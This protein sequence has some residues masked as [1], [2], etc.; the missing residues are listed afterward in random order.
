ME[1]PEGMAM[2]H[3]RGPPAAG[4]PPGG[5]PQQR[6]KGSGEAV[7]DCIKQGYNVTSCVVLKLLEWM[8]VKR[9]EEARLSMFS[10]EAAVGLRNFSVDTTAVARYLEAVDRELRSMFPLVLRLTV[11]T[12]TPLAVHLRNPYMPLEIGLAW[13]PLFNAPYIPA[14]TL[15]GAL[16]AGARRGACGLPPADL[17]GYVGQEG[18]LVI[19]DA[20]PTSSAAVEPDVITPHYK[21]PDVREDRAEPTPLVFPVV[22]PGATFDFFVASRS[23]EARC[24]KEIYSLINEALAEGL[25]AKTR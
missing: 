8:R 22:K 18:A 25:G 1:P 14:T 9:G 12:E 13:H 11:E 2:R 20:L 21:E 15:K 7:L 10:R 3:Q 23:I 6:E 4:G 17:F 16:R 5:R 24:T 19:T